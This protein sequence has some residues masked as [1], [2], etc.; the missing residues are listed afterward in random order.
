MSNVIPLNRR[1]SVDFDAIEKIRQRPK[2][3]R[4]ERI[5]GRLRAVATGFAVSVNLLA[6]HK[7]EMA[8]W[9]AKN[10][11]KHELGGAEKLLHELESTAR[12]ARMIADYIATARLRL[13]IVAGFPIYDDDVVL[14]LREVDD[15][16]DA[17]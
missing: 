11:A 15:G 2:R 6:M 5:R 1:G 16:D 4:D 9:L 17:A 3:E 8:N 13:A 14:D 7:P 10:S 12:Q